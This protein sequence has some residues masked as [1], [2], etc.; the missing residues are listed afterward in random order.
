MRFGISE[1]E[2]TMSD[3]RKQLARKLFKSTIQP[4]SSLHIFL[5]PPPRDHPCITL[6]RASSKCCR[7]PTRT[8]KCQ[9]FFSHALS[10]SLSD[11]IIVVSLY[12][13]HVF[14]SLCVTISIYSTVYISILPTWLLLPINVYKP[15]NLWG[16][17]WPNG[18]N[19]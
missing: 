14:V 2:P 1:Y 17:V 8:K 7:I 5:P 9:S 10:L 3:R 11:F 6:L 18:L 13:L 4:T 12:L 19:T 15:L 16:P